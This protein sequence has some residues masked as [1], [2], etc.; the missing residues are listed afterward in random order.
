MA[1]LAAEAAAKSK[2]DKD[3]IDAQVKARMAILERMERQKIE[4]AHRQEM[5]ALEQQAKAQ[6]DALAW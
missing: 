3:L 4:M 2:G 6:K 1:K 5:A